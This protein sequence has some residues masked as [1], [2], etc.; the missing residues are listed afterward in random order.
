MAE[1]GF[2]ASMTAAMIAPNPVTIGATVITGGIYVGVKAY[3]HWGEVEKAW[4]KTV[5]W[6]GDK[7]R[8]IG[9][10]VV[11]GAKSLAKKA[12]PMNWF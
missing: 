3:E 1:A 11:H 8:E 12:N 5:H 6:T 10:G 4:G 7:A 2:N 9:S